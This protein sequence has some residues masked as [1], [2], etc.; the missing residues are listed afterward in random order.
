MYSF[1]SHI[2]DLSFAYLSCSQ[3]QQKYHC[4]ENNNKGEVCVCCW[5]WWGVPLCSRFYSNLA[6]KLP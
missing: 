6:L 3:T 4:W 1:L 5:W 2:S